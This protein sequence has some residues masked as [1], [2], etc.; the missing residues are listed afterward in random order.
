MTSLTDTRIL[1]AG[2]TGNVG[3]HL[4]GAV[5]AAGGTAIVPSRAA[6]KVEALEREHAAHA[7]RLVPLIG[8]VTDAQAAADLL[9]R[10]GPIHGAAA[11]L[12]PGS[13][14]AA[15][16]ILKAPMADL[17]RALD[18][19]LAAYF[20]VSAIRHPRLGASGRRLRHDQ[21]SAGR[22]NCFRGTG[23]VSVATAGQAMLARVLMQELAEESRY[24]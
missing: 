10:A 13:F 19:Y 9:D 4:V 5:L 21:R 3:R 12:S 17:R 14:I 18:G 11:T 7:G 2:G 16:S 15:P 24:A 20:T 23:L 8:D 1:I 22:S 6:A